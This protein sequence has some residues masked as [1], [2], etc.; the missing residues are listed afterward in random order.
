MTNPFFILLVSS[1]AVFR[2]AELVAVDNGPFHISKKLRDLCRENPI[3][4]EFVNCPYCIGGWLSLA[5]T[6]ML[7]SNK[8]LP[9]VPPAIWWPAIWGGAAAI[10][11]TVR[12]RQ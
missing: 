10:L 3:L 7:Y 2:L 6:A 8:C 9:E 5:F 1:L 11:R 4:S 12:E